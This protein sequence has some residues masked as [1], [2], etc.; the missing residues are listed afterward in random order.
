MADFT[1]TIATAVFETPE[2][3]E[4]F[5]TIINNHSTL[6]MELY[7]YL[8]FDRF[9]SH[10][11][12]LAA[13][14]AKWFY[15][16]SM[17]VLDGCEV[18][19]YIESAN[20]IPNALLHTIAKNENCIVHGY[21]ETDYREAWTLFTFNPTSGNEQTYNSFLGDDVTEFVDWC[22]KE[23]F[24]NLDELYDH[25]DI[26]Y[27]FEEFNGGDLIR[28]FYNIK[29]GWTELFYFGMPSEF[30]YTVEDVRL[31]KEDIEAR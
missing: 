5:A 15:F 10:T 30:T 22:K 6:D 21:A 27:G 23:K 26:M 12:A 28:E 9:P 17:P 31:I 13:G 25:C 2:R 19:M 20:F 18:H 1:Y 4:E 29:H 16:D 14:G 7:T 8:G 24:I 11:D 3:A